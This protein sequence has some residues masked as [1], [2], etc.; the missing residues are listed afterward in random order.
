MKYNNNI[1]EAKNKI[2]NKMKK[3][4]ENYQ[5]FIGFK[6]NRE[7]LDSMSKDLFEVWEQYKNIDHISKWVDSPKIFKMKY[8][9]ESKEIVEKLINDYSNLN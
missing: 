6:R 1:V 3:E 9:D 8:K 7:L 2:K 4:K 5:K